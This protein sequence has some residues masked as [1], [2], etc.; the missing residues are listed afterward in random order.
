MK[1]L[2]WVD[3]MVKFRRLWPEMSY[4]N[5]WTYDAEFED[6]LKRCTIAYHVEERK[7]PWQAMQ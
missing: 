5:V 6:I 7:L 2:I 4:T 1:S 3:D